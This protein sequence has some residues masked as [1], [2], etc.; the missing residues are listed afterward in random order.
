M[1]LVLLIRH[2]LAETTGKRLSG[3]MPGVHLSAKGR[4]QAERLAERL[5][6][7]PIR[8]IYSSPL[9]RCVETAEPLAASSGVD[10]TLRADLGEVRYGEWTNR[11][12]AQLAR[13]R[14]WKVV[15]SVPSRARFPG[16]ESL[17][18]VQERSVREI[19][20]IL[21]SHPKAVVAVF[22]HGD[23]I[24]LLVAHFSGLH[25]DLFQRLVI[26]PAS[27]S[28]I[29][30]GNGAPRILKVNDTGGLSDLAPRPAA[31]K[32]KAAGAAARKVRG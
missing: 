30:A 8:A 5:A 18:E 1:A 6:G 27:V 21:A 20:R 31:R 7:V 32:T 12:L 10:V 22:S 2:A 26:D 11:P 14:L 13:T 25:P 16:G 23:V 9:E 17:L 28:A 4:E 3:W 15:Q 24:R 29:A 19:E